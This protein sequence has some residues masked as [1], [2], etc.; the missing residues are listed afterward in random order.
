MEVT[1][2]EFLALVVFLSLPVL[3]AGTGAALLLLWR[4]RAAASLPKLARVG[5]IAASQLLATGGSIFIWAAWP[6]GVRDM[7]LEFVFVPAVLAQLAILPALLG[8]VGLRSRR[9]PRV[10]GDAA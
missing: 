4:W 10:S 2:A 8:V 1:T 7:V 5:M 3:L 9:R 6:E